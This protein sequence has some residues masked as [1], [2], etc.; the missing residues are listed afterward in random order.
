MGKKFDD[1]NTTN[2]CLQSNK[3]KRRIL[4]LSSNIFPNREM[5]TI[6]RFACLHLLWTEYIPWYSNYLLENFLNSNYGWESLLRSRGSYNIIK[7]D[8]KWS[9]HYITCR[10]IRISSVIF[11]FAR[12]ILECKWNMAV[13]IIW[14]G[15]TQSPYS[16]LC[17]D[18]N[19]LR[20]LDGDVST[21]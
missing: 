8:V 10:I 6:T 16:I 14:V 20:Q 17:R 1:M 11:I 9:V 5:I 3:K 18:R 4:I 19:H 13:K 2:S 15:A 12:T 7:S 21:L